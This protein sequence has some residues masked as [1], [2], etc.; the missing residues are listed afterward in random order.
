M[1]D[2]VVGVFR[3]RSEAEFALGKLKDSSP[4]GC[5]EHSLWRT[6]R[7]SRRSCSPRSPARPR[8]ASP[9][10]SSAWRRPATGDRALYFEQEVEAGRFLVS[11]VGARLEVAREILLEAGALE[12]AP[13]EAPLEPRERPRPEGG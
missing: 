12:A 4:A 3:T 6:G 10:R 1:R 11:V 13:V 8:A 9:A 5:P 2:T 7:S